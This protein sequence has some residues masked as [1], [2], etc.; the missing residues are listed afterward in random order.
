M[1]TL[2]DLRTF[3]KYHLKHPVASHPEREESLGVTP[4]GYDPADFAA[5]LEARRDD[6]EISV[7]A[8]FRYLGVD[9]PMHRLSSGPAEEGP[10]LLVLS[11]VHG[12]EQAGILAI[13]PW[14][15]RLRERALP[16]ASMVLTPVNPVGAAHLS[17]YN[18]QG[19]DINRDFHR[20]ETEEARVVVDMVDRFRPTAIVSLHEGPQD[21]AFM[22]ANHLVTPALAAPILAGLRRR[23]VPLAERDYFGRRLAEPGLAASTRATR[24]LEALWV[25]TLGMQSSN[26]FAAERGIPELTFETPWRV[27]DP[28]ARVGAQVAFLDSV[29]DA[30]GA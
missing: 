3:A 28:E 27:P 7:E 20:L 22:F 14:L 10:R 23:G 16:F 25:K 5:A 24:A 11:G 26:G 6:V 19:Y 30:L 13:L 2:E 18:A 21:A 8:S 15:D 29:V 1:V 9:H 4:L 12:N 17:R